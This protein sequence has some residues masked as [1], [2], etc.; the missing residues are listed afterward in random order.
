MSIGRKFLLL[1]GLAVIGPLTVGMLGMLEMRQMDNGQAFTNG[2]TIPGIRIVHKIESDFRDTRIALLYHILNTETDRKAEQEKRIADL[3]QELQAA[4][5][6]Y[7]AY[8]TDEQD[9]KLRDVTGMLMQE[10][11]F[12]SEQVI[13]LSR[14]HMDEAARSLAEENKPMIE[15]L[16]AN[17]SKHVEYKESQA[18]QQG[19]LAHNAYI[20]GTRLMAGV[21]LLGIVSST[22]LGGMLY[23]SVTGSLQKMLSMFERVGRE[24]DFTARLPASSRDEIGKTENALNA[25]LERLQGSIRHICE[26]TVQLNS[27]A[28]RMATN[29]SQMSEASINQREAANHIANTVQELTVSAEEAAS[30]ADNAKQLSEESLIKARE[31]ADVIRLT[32]ADINSISETVSISSNQVRRLDESST[33]IDAVVSVIKDVAEQTNLLA[34]NAAIEA[35]RAGEHGRGFAVVADE[36]RKLAERTAHST[37]EIWTNISQMHATAHETVE[38]IQAVANKVENGVARANEADREMQGIGASSQSVARM[39]SDIAIAVARQK[40]A[41]LDIAAQVQGIADMSRQ[42]S[43]A[44][45]STAATAVELARLARE[46]SGA[47]KSYC[48]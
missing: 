7:D 44:A 46:M 42:N 33:R 3:H 29:A 28:E 21:I 11:F 2:M 36:V 38:G 24:L 20:V 41:N 5:K 6:S 16:N 13:A 26:I 15:Q 12:M 17:I 22:L 4:L 40:D 8:V 34:L 14:G 31:S 9:K 23:R 1:I 25:L 18:R 43:R 19:E 47:V 48:V 32:V 45:E 35:A 27:A 37:D 30:R 10:Y 39:V